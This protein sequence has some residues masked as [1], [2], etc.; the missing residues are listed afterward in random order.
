MTAA[1]IA[2]PLVVAMNSRATS[3]YR[4]TAGRRTAIFSMILSKVDSCLVI[5]QPALLDFAV[6][7]P[8]EEADDD[9]ANPPVRCEA[10]SEVANRVE[11]A[12]GGLNLG[13][14]FLCLVERAGLLSAAKDAGA[15]QNL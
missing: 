2:L 3:V 4:E 10:G 6:E 1:M 14:D 5:F 11:D 8:S 9:D 13:D 7:L 15:N 12:L